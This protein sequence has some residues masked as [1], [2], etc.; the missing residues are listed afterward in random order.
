MN[1]RGGCFWRAAL[2]IC[3]AVPGWA[4][5]SPQLMQAKTA[6]L[7]V[8]A[9]RPPNKPLPSGASLGS[10]PLLFEEG[11]GAEGAG[12]GYVARGPGYHFNF[13]PSHISMR[14]GA[15]GSSA[16]NRKARGTDVRMSWPGA[17]GLA[18]PEAEDRLAATTNYFI[19][20]DSS[21]WRRDVA[22]YERVRY[23]E[24][25]PGI[26]LVFYG[27]QS[28]MEYDIVVAPGADPGRVH[29]RFD[30][31]RGLRI[32]PEGDLVISTAAGEM[33]QRRP[34]V[35]Q[36]AG[37]GRRTLD[38]RYVLVGGREV[39]FAVAAFDHAAPLV[40]DPIVDYSG[41]IGGT[42]ADVAFSAAVDSAGNLYLAGATDSVDLPVTT[43]AVGRAKSGGDDVFVAKLDNSG[44]RLVYLT[45]FGGTNLD[46]AFDIAADSQGNAYVVGSTMSP[47]IPRVGALSATLNGKKDAFYFKLSPAGNQLIYSSYF[48]GSEL[49]IGW[50]IA[51]DL[52]QAVYIAGITNSPDLP[53]R[54]AAQGSLR[55]VNAFLAKVNPDGRSI[56]YA[57]YWGG[58]CQDYFHSISLD[59][60]G[61]VLAAGA[62]CSA[63]FPVRN[64][65][66][67][68]NAG[69]DDVVVAKFD[70]QGRAVYSTYVG[71]AN[72][73]DAYSVTA[74]PN[75]DAFV[76]GYTLSTDF[77]VSG[78][79]AQGRN[80]SRSAY[81]A[82]VLRLDA[83]GAVVYATYLGGSGD[84]WGLGIA[85]DSS[86][87]SYVTGVTSSP[88]F[89]VTAGAVQSKN[90][91]FWNAFVTKVSADGSSLLSSTYFGGG[92]RDEAYKIVSDGRGAV[93]VAGST[94]S[95]NFP[96]AG[97]PP[98]RL[99]RGVVDAFVA[100]LEDDSCK[101]TLS[102]YSSVV[103]A[104]GTNATMSVATNT[105]TCNWSAASTADWITFR[106]ATAGRGAG[107]LSYTVAPNTSAATRTGAI[108]AGGQRLTVTQA[109]QACETAAFP[110]S[111]T[112]P[113][114]AEVLRVAIA[115][116][117]GPNCSWQA[118]SDQPWL[119]LTGSSRGTG[120]GTLAFLVDA[121]NQPDLRAGAISL[122]GS[123]TQRISVVQAAGGCTLTPSSPQAGFSSFGG[124]GDIRVATTSPACSWTATAQDSWIDLVPSTASGAGGGTI[125]FAVGQNGTAESRVATFNIN[126]QS[127]SV[128]QLGPC[129]PG[130][131]AGIAP[132]GCTSGTAGPSAVL[133]PATMVGK[134]VQCSVLTAAPVSLSF[135]ADGGAAQRV[136]FSGCSQVRVLT[137][138]PSWITV[139]WISGTEADVGVTKS[140]DGGK[141]DFTISFQ[142]NGLGNASVT[143]TRLGAGCSFSTIPNPISVSAA[144]TSNGTLQVNPD[145]A[146]C[147]WSAAASADWITLNGSATG[148]G[149]GTLPYAVRANTA[150]S[151][152]VANIKL[153]ETEAVPIEQAAG[154][155]SFTLPTTTAAASG[156]G[157]DR[158][159]HVT[160]SDPTCPWTA[161]ADDAWITFPNGVS[162]AGG[163]DLAFRVAQNPT[164]QARTTTIRVGNSQMAV[165]QGGTMPPCQYSVNPGYGLVV[166]AGGAGNF[167]VTAPFYC[168]WTALP[169]DSFVTISS[170][171][172][173]TGNGTVSYNAA[174]GPDGATRTGRITVQGQDH[175][176]AGVDYAVLQ[177]PP[178]SLSAA[179][180]PITASCNASGL[181][182]T[183]LVWTAPAVPGLQI[184]IKG[185]A[186]LGAVAASGTL[187]TGQTVGNGT[188]FQLLDGQGN[189][190]A[191]TT[192]SVKCAS[193]ISA[194]PN[195][196][197]QCTSAGV[198]K[199]TINWSAPGWPGLQL[200]IGAPDGVMMG[201][202]DPMGTATT[203]A[204]VTD[205]MKFF[206]VS[207]GQPLGSVAVGVHCA[208]VLTS[209]LIEGN[210]ADW[211]V[212]FTR[213]G[214]P[215]SGVALDEKVSYVSGKASF[216]A[217]SDTADGVTFSFPRAQ[218]GWVLDLS[219]FNQMKLWLA[220]DG[221]GGMAPASPVVVLASANGNVVLTPSQP[222]VLTPGWSP[223][224]I[225]IGGGGI[226]VAR[227]TGAFD[228]TAV[229]SIQIGVATAT[230]GF[231]LLL[232]GLIFS[233]Q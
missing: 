52:T 50:G 115:S 34:H 35:Y 232:D 171:S 80:G 24:V 56:G 40:I 125:R 161:N 151:K 118:V 196:I 22:T 218:T 53:V 154:A 182:T 84:D 9:L 200:R 108:T 227:Q 38:G 97:N 173:G 163:A 82:F 167:T 79:P 46:R 113:N 186:S 88:D 169:A 153:S 144:G 90:S 132:S 20:P 142:G 66:Q 10:L 174:A 107:S 178:A 68:V 230:P 183:T 155:C 57:T 221:S 114:T 102:Q 224:T 208:P 185:G 233:R 11:T 64:A 8:S 172:T 36:V 31:A 199:T 226:W 148:K 62:T 117:A 197:T 212:T 51:V 78:N 205:G 93:Y 110:N 83:S 147:N 219:P 228:P 157:E 59:G 47:D 61:N 165:T 141:A 184:Q 189:E 119:H 69:A 39:G 133:R 203:D 32:S 123:G 162:A 85:A 54:N 16:A 13:A 138:P 222:P 17:R 14:F 42:D 215:D 190:L 175:S 33:L 229:T 159:V 67:P 18:L 130:L 192:V 164:P 166:P 127:F 129:P 121:N 71:G 145:A 179:P 191:S 98:Q 136:K 158:V 101:V 5:Q 213:G 105:S 160:A 187:S 87:N 63:D 143:V 96:V 103:P 104:A 26:D 177:S 231:G 156:A 1:S 168:S 140:P 134:E 100:R 180:S 23:R 210:I 194:S 30:G 120:A 214:G 45:Y 60:L 58:S 193:G 131:Q 207:N 211:N 92:G 86:G 74:G 220:F 7:S 176:V 152:R 216:L 37:G 188:V 128:V 27:N 43:G 112:L 49:E 225:P 124:I 126:D 201:D 198:G 12:P 122:S 91:G 94:T 181:G 202:V 146:T 150:P 217:I 106:S 19:G 195:P 206:L 41:Y 204:W 89:P 111:F 170:G 6:A 2:G 3:C 76:T 73:D 149:A 95:D 28:R 77:P 116:P 21:K 75:G 72:M 65:A 70:S 55:G 4:A 223:L 135:P 25:W 209:D 109:G 48:G 15:A 99:F 139:N 137:P 44:T 81:D 29:F